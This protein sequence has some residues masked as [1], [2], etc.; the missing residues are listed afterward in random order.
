MKKTLFIL[1]ILSLLFM[2]SFWSFRFLD[3]NWIEKLSQKLSQFT[4]ERNAERVYLHF[5]KPFY[6]PSETIWFQ[7]Y[8]QNETTLRPSTQSEILHVELIDPKGNVAK[9]LH[10]ILKEGTASGDFELEENAAGGLYKVR[11]YTQWQENFPQTLIFEKE[12][13]VQKV[14]LPRLKM[15]LQFEKEAY[16][17][18]DLVEATLTLEDLKN[19]ALENQQVKAQILLENDLFLE[20]SF[21]TDA[22]GK[23]QV[24]FQL[25]AKLESNDGLL[26]I[27]FAYQGQTESISRAIPI[28]LNRFTLEFLPEGGEMIADFENKIAFLAKDEYGKAADLAG[29]I[30]DTKGAV[31][32][33]FESYHKGMGAFL[34]R[35]KAGERYSARLISP[36]KV[37]QTYPL[38]EVL[39]IGYGL[40]L[41]YYQ[42]AQ[43]KPKSENA[44]PNYDFSNP[45]KKITL[46]APKEERLSL[47]AQIRGEVVFAKEFL[48]DKGYNQL[49]FDTKKM[50]VGV[51]QITLFDSKGI[52][53]AERLFFNQKENE[54]M[55]IRLETDKD[56]YQ[57][58]EKVTLTLRTTDADGIPIPA[59]V[60][61]S[62]AEAKLLSFAD[63][64]SS[65]I[66]SFLLL[67][68]DLQ[69]EIEDPQFYFDPKEEKAAQGLELLTLTQGWRKFE[70][71]QIVDA[72][73]FSPQKAAEK[74]LIAG[75]VYEANG[76]P[77][78]GRKVLI[79]GTEKS[80]ITDQNGRFSFEGIA[81]YEP[82]SITVEPKEGAYDR[83]QI[84][85]YSTDI[86]LYAYQMKVFKSR[87]VQ[88]EG[89]IF[90]KGNKE[91]AEEMDWMGGA[92]IPEIE[93]EAAPLDL[94][95]M[96]A[97]AKPMMAAE[98]P[99]LEAAQ[100]AEEAFF[101]V[102]DDEFWDGDLIDKKKDEAPAPSRYYR[103]R[104]FPA[105][106]YSQS[107]EVEV[108]ND[109]RS[110]IFWSGNVRTDQKG[111]ATL[112]FYN[113]D[114]IS[115][116]Q[117]TCEGVGIEGSVGRAQKSY[118]TQKPLSLDIKVPLF[119]AMGDKIEIP[120]SLANS[121]KKDIKGKLNLKLPTAW[122]PL[123]EKLLQQELT[124]KA[125]ETQTIFLPFEVLNV[126]GKDTFALA[127][128]SEK[129]RDAF[130]Q[131]VFING[132][133]FPSAVSFSAQE[134]EKSYTFSILNPVEGTLRADFSAYPSPLSD[135]LAGIESILREPY[136]CFEQTSSSTYPN[137]LVLEYL[138]DNG[139]TQGE[140]VTRA[141]NLIE[142]GYKRLV[143]YETKDKGYEWF[144]SNPPHEAL[145][146]YGLME[147]R[148]MQGVMEKVVE[149]AMVKRTADW[150]L[151]RKDGKGGFL[152]NDKALDSFGRADKEI[153]DAYIVYSLTEAGFSANLT[154]EI[155]G[156]YQ[157]ATTSQDPYQMALLANILYNTKDKRAEEVLKNLLKMQT[158][159]GAWEGK[160]HSIT[161]S[162]GNGLH[163]ETT[164]LALLA[165][166]KAD[167]KAA[168]AIQNGA[169]FLIGSRN[170]GGFGNTQSTVLALKALTEFAKFAKKAQ[171][172]GTIEIWVAG[173]KVATKSYQKGEEN[174][175]LIANLEKHLQKGENTLSVKFVGVKNALPYTL[176]IRYN[177]TLP[178]SSPQCEIELQTKLAKGK[179]QVG[180]TVRL[181]AT[182]SNKTKEGKAMTVAIL[183]IAGGLSPQPWQLK[184]LQEEGKYDFYEVR[185]NSV[186][187]YYRQMKP[188]EV[189][190]VELDLK[191]EIAGSYTAKASTAY[192]YYTNEHKTWVEAQKIEV[193]K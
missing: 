58:R 46:F 177:S 160:K 79:E 181:S 97:V 148:D 135:M 113:S 193:A 1:P 122:K 62:V 92:D 130:E 116:F 50:P 144:G 90:K 36:Q 142:Q 25:P 186:I 172:D 19:Q 52:E 75:T 53:R 178:Q 146:A 80:A 109:F 39:P 94:P 5:D 85:E 21:T 22:A 170:Y 141:Q 66:L 117:I 140:V 111:V 169:K 56:S 24:A 191:A 112:T 71:Q 128:E 138:Q 74:A 164:S 124:L 48:A 126:M 182:I 158:E 51:V 132:K 125:G 93:A 23:A 184:K 173:K 27:K 91:K 166:L 77:A 167:Q 131:E 123:N 171:E 4:Q 73:T 33:T 64:K 118:F 96:A 44:L 42:Q 2:A 57:P 68:S 31:V 47:I 176:S 41:E 150:L 61:L 187:L 87:A 88:R 185:E 105:P 103:A 26:N 72:K 40:R 155:E 14:I 179:T 98:K 86:A 114:E 143:S 136:G 28:K 43:T 161:V 127:F 134:V 8:V 54:G 165:A 106:D 45:S 162:T 107:Q 137:I 13:Q 81:L 7:A 18:A 63:D 30:I 154:A 100:E 108:R 180:E 29:E 168:L 110:T 9:K 6:K 67:E 12:M 35:P 49:D 3:D 17:A 34:F 145:T 95:Q 151:S 188:K 101:E 159:K 15:K 76:D 37:A 157:N 192:L 174:Q 139:V 152:R 38:P 156:V 65:H 119:M 153:T 183:G 163:I 32:A 10:L 82:I 129:Y 149:E 89:R 175:I 120:L 83:K 60:S 121:T 70:W 20:K 147:F 104:V 55:K 16:G 84:S 115:A 189:R 99:L 190:T 102:L 78:K 11:A 59:N 133:G 69:G